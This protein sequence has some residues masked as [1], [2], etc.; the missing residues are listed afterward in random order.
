MATSSPSSSSS[1]S[2]A[3]TTACGSGAAARGP[4]TRSTGGLAAR[5]AGG[6]RLGRGRRGSRRFR[7]GLIGLY[8]RR[9]RLQA[10]AMRLADHRI[11]AHA[12]QLFGDLAGSA[13]RCPTSSSA[14]RYALRSSSSQI[15][16]SCQLACGRRRQSLAR[17]RMSSQPPFGPETNHIQSAVVNEPRRSCHPQCQLGRSSNPL[18]Q[19][20]AT[21][22]QGAAPDDLGAGDHKPC[23]T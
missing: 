23:C 11:T 18:Y 2:S 13:A 9:A 19:G 12:A 10:K 20:G 5:E 14:Y 15:L 16:K 21:F 8:R 1:S 22:L 7:I 4:A 6:R 17:S 3:I